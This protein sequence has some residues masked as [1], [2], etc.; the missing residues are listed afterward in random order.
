M[1][2]VKAA[3]QPTGSRRITRVARGRAIQRVFRPRW[4]VTAASK[5]TLAADALAPGQI[6]GSRTAPVAA[7]VADSVA[8]PLNAEEAAYLQW[9]QELVHS[10]Y[11]NN[12]QREYV[13]SSQQR[14]DL[15]EFV[16]T[17]LAPAF[18]LGLLDERASLI[19]ERIEELVDDY[20]TGKSDRIDLLVK[21]SG[22][23]FTPLR[24]KQAWLDYDAYVRLSKR[25]LVAPSFSEI[26]HILNLAQI[27]A[28][29]EDHDNLRLVTFDGD[30][31]LYEDGHNFSPN[32]KLVDRLI[33][34]MR[35]GLNV[36]L[37]T[38][39]GYPG[40]PIRYEERIGGLL[41]GMRE[42]G[43]TEEECGRLLVL[44]GE[45]NFLFRCDHNCHL[46]EVPDEEWM[47]PAQRWCRE[48]A[49]TV[50]DVAE[51]TLRTLCREL[52]LPAQVVRKQL[53][54][55]IIRS[56]GGK[57]LEREQLD[58]VVLT[59]QAELRKV[60][61]AQGGHLPPFCAFNGG[62]DA[63]VDVGNKY[64]GLRT[65]QAYLGLQPR[66][67]LHVGD[68]FTS[69]GNDISTR[70]ACPTIWIRDPSETGRVVKQISRSVRD[71]DVFANTVTPR[72]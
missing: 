16:K 46:Q 51:T 2:A 7:S 66:Q 45:S 65:L 17:M 23:F 40:N 27:Y 39:A 62:A 12:Q 59:V 54:V 5:A 50:L 53:A 60:R 22:V 68:Q 29:T 9:D 42:R 15:I 64:I 11:S 1:A 49:T 21:P 36:A 38:A 71:M 25:T 41:R 48:G 19:F 13:L 35:R 34:L 63:W 44:G 18:A 4:A 67:V 14:D 55:G 72:E 56:E 37:V 47:T 28:S 26:R 3:R 52:N 70:S 10:S 58:E 8:E 32:S 24:L 33:I 57:R 30:K 6:G 43:L 31:T 20:R 69:V 61:L